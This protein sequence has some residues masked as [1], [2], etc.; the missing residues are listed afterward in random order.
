[1]DLW[2]FI[3]IVGIAMTLHGIHHPEKHLEAI[4]ADIRAEL[5]HRPSICHPLAGNDPWVA[6][7][8]R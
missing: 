7:L 3:L 6:T 5:S 1:M 8:S 4:D 2:D